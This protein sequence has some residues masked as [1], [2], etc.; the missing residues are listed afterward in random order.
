MMSRFVTRR[1]LAAVVLVVVG[2][3]AFRTALLPPEGG[4][5]ADPILTQGQ[6][7]NLTSLDQQR[8]ATSQAVARQVVQVENVGVGLGSGVIATVNGYIVTNNHV[9]DGGTRFYVT[10]WNGTRVAATLV[11]S[12]PADD[13]AV[14]KVNK[15]GLSAARFGNSD[16]LLVGQEVLAIGNPLGLGETVTAGLVSAMRR[17]VSEGTGTYLPHAIQTSAPINPGNSGG[18]LVSLDGQVVGIPTL[19]AGSPEGGAAQ[20]IGFAIPSNHVVSIADQLITQGR[21]THTSR[22]YLGISSAD[23]S[24]AAQASPLQ[25][26]Q[27]TASGVLVQQVGPGSPAEGAG[28]QAGD[29][30]V[31]LAGRP[32]QNTDS[33]VSILAD[34]TVGQK[35]AVGIERTDQATGAAQNLTLRVT[36]GELP[37]KP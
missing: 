29:V 17:T 2:G 16:K 18:A 3:L 26:A 6:S 35:V 36:L 14:L 15:T 25:P 34:L 11:G 9:V 21:V 23:A 8:T 5:S 10:L 37:A 30:I 22:A 13:L 7:F 12:S 1:A 4:V 19:G 24:R 20:G 28:L 27:P 32:V 33:L 31:R